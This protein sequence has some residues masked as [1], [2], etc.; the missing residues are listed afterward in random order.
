MFVS[1]DINIHIT[2]NIYF[3]RF[4]IKRGGKK[5]KTILHGCLRALPINITVDTLFARFNIT[6]GEKR[7]KKETEEC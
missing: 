7:K 1:S 6:R 2:V 5:K 4:D 3:A